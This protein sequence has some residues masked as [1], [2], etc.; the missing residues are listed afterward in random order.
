MKINFF[1]NTAMPTRVCTIYE[2][3]HATMVKSSSCHRNHTTYKTNDITMCA[4]TESSPDP[5]TGWSITNPIF[6]FAKIFL[7]SVI[8]TE[9]D[10]ELME[11]GKQ[12]NIYHDCTAFLKAA[13]HFRNPTWG[14]VTRP[15]HWQSLSH[16]GNAPSTSSM[17]T[18][19]DV[20]D[21]SNNVLVFKT[22]FFFY[23]IFF[24][25]LTS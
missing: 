3:F 19:L 9:G 17:S 11:E 10:Y 12:A 5:W 6:S 25:F 1:L 24:Y 13:F 7:F 8:L 14:Y 15:Q 16:I 21:L 4:Y 22:A 23:F 2:C 18:P 20:M